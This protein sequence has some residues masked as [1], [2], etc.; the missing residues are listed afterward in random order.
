MAT[1]HVTGLVATLMEHRPEFQ[2]NPALL[3]AHLMASTIAHDD[4]TGKSND[5]G[6]G[7][8]SSYMAHW[9]TN[10]FLRWWTWG[11]VS[12]TGWH[13]FD[14]NVPAGAQ[15][16]VV[17]MTWDEP[18]ASAG[19][20][21]AVTWDVDL[22][23]DYLADC[24]DPK[25][26][27]GE[28][29]SISGID[30]VEYIVINNP[31]A[32]LYRLKA[33]NFRAP[34][35]FSLPVGIGATVIMGDPT[36]AMSVSLSAPSSVLA[37]QAFTVTGTV[38]TP[39]YLA[40]GVQATLTGYSAG[41]TLINMFTERYDGVTTVFP[42][43]EI[44]TDTLTLGN[45]FPGVSRSVS[46]QFRADT[47]G[48]KVFNTRFWSENGGTQSPSATSQVVA[49]LAD[50]TVSSVT[51]APAAPFLLPGGTFSVTD[52]VVSNG[53]KSSVASTTRYYLSFDGAK[54]AGDTLLAATRAV[55]AL[56]PGAG[57]T[58]TVVLTIPPNMALSTYFLLACADDL[59]TNAEEN[60]TNNCAVATTGAITVTR[61][62]LVEASAAMTPTSPVRAVGGTFSVT[63]T[64]FNVG[65]VAAGTSTT[66]YYLSIDGAKSA[67]DILLTGSRP[68]P[69][70]A[71]NTSN[72]GT[73]TVT[74]P[75]TTAVGTY[76]L[77]ACAD[78]LNAVIETDN[79]NCVFANPGQV[80][81]TRSDLIMSTVSTNPATMV[82]AP[83]GTFSVTDAT[84]NA[85][86]LPSG[87]SITRY[88]LSLNGSKDAGDVLLTGTRAVPAL[89]AGASHS[90]TVTVTIPA[91]TPLNNYV[92]LACADDTLVVAE[93]VETNNC[94]AASGVA[95][96]RV[97][98]ADL[99]E[100]S[101]FTT[102]AAPVRAPGTTFSITD[103]AKNVGAV[104]SPL[105]T[106]RY[107]LSLNQTKGAGDILL[108]GART[109]PALA[110]NLTSTAA[111]TVTIPSTTP[112]ATYFVLACADD[113][114][115]VVE[116]DE[117]NNCVASSSGQVVVTRPDLVAESVTPPPT[118]KARGTSFTVTDTVRN[119][120]AVASGASTTRYYLSLDGLKNAG[121]TLLTGSRA[122]PGLAAGATSPPGTVTVTIPST[123][124]LNTYVLLACADD[125]N[126]VVETIETNNC[127]ASATGVT[128]TP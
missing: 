20:S 87:A 10:D 102:P 23:V 33:S 21:Q 67:G 4:V 69:G 16:M 92:V 6:I 103:T 120:G 108:T 45:V 26:A 117:T 37:G 19:A 27:C 11:S 63:D 65:Q 77:L 74:I 76:Y 59:N 3:R 35:A 1:P 72:S 7:R 5:Y 8:V 78:D 80:T 73:A 88:Y 32:G 125:L 61:P 99:T 46:W 49:P 15:R 29:S 38:T 109:V 89:A 30:N 81:V 75:T 86:Q 70:L 82:R 98:R 126:T 128:V 39:S 53:S 96:V 116:T 83:G 58:G 66:R 44:T 64:V 100:T 2:N 9:P 71:K 31:P 50:L 90:G 40:S 112:V 101:A 91:T 22:Y 127:T 17:V 122:V 107:Y 47:T 106:T 105:S 52:R 57:S 93:T 119:A 25:G 60:E 118:S 56:P 94:L 124:L 24:S 79:S 54:N 28:W 115:Q 34:S 55:P 13:F 111:V 42:P 62:N 113:T 41:L 84:L 104:A 97:T 12:A 36:P 110:E 68:V 18:A 85:G 123:T 14:I 51:T 43:A 95:A 48:T 114:S 121:D